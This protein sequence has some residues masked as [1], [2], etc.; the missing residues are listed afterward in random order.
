MHVFIDWWSSRVADTPKWTSRKKLYVDF[1][2]NSVFFFRNAFLLLCIQLYDLIGT[3][4]VL[5]KIRLRERV[6]FCIHWTE[7]E[8]NSFYGNSLTSFPRPFWSSK[9]IIF[10]FSF[11]LSFSQIF[12][13]FFPSY[14]VFWFSCKFGTETFQNFF[15]LVQNSQYFR[16]FRTYLKCF[17]TSLKQGMSL[18]D[19]FSIL[20]HLFK[21]LRLISVSLNF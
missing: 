21:T 6:T 11:V 20:S 19:S 8:L 1:F 5:R 14:T 17:R 15:G 4:A 13:F 12:S 9:N 7:L 16:L 3:S 18:Q 2:S 10:Y